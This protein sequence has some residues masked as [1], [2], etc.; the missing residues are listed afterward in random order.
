MA[1][2]IFL[3][4]SSYVL[5]SVPTGYLMGKALKGVDIR[6]VG[7]GNPGATNV[8]RSV[9]KTAGIVTLLIDM[10][11]GWVPVFLAFKLTQGETVPL[12]CGLMAVVGHTWSMFLN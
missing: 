11:K 3:I 1:L 9:G 4:L 12:V 5:G 2:I 10:A 7:S 6:R 8:F